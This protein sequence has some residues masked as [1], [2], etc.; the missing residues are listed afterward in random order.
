MRRRDRADRLLPVAS[1]LL[2]LAGVLSLRMF[3][4]L[5]QETQP[6][7]APMKYSTEA[8]WDDELLASRTRRTHPRP[9]IWRL[10]RRH[11]RTPA[12]LLQ[13]DDDLP[14]AVA[15]P[16]TQKQAEAPEEA[17]SA[18]PDGFLW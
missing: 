4:A 13:V 14:S 16:P 10:T 17:E 9:R 6:S 3:W 15:A 11:S 7:A 12:V 5:P 1:C 8:Y 2:T 18:L